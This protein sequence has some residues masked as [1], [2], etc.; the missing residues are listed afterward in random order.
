MAPNCSPDP[1]KTQPRC[2][3]AELELRIRAVVVLI[4]RGARRSDVLHHCSTTW[5]LSVRQSDRILN[6][7]REQIREDWQ[8]ERP[9][10]AAELLCKLSDLQ[11]EAR[12]T[13][14]LRTAL[15]CI[16]ATAKLA[17]LYV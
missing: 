2:T 4:L 6:L 13:G 14:D 8:M 1:R 17:G 15:A 12:Q 7:A 16:N 11:Q 10:L 3:T 5:G 9:E